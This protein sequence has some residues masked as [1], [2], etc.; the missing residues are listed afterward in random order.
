MTR[1]GQAPVPGPPTP[2]DVVVIGAGIV[3]LSSALY[4]QRDGHRVTILDPRE[5]GTATSFGNAGGIVVSS[6]VPLGTP[7]VLRQVPGMLFDP[8]SALSVRWRYLPRAMPWLVDF[9]RASRPSRVE[10]IS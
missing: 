8:K 5:P 4:L 9:V 1:T 3:G 7:G 10:E 2:R 6:C